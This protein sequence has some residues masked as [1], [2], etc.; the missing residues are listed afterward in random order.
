MYY[1][2]YHEDSTPEGDP[3]RLYVKNKPFP[4]WGE[5]AA[6]A[7]TVDKSRKPRIVMEVAAQDF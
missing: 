3:G 2:I 7:R 4:T 1:V 6:Y 5:A